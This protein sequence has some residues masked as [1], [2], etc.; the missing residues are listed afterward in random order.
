MLSLKP[1]ALVSFAFIV[2]FLLALLPGYGQSAQEITPLEAKQSIDRE[3]TTGEDQVY[4]LTLAAV[5]YARVEL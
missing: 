3:L 4:H 2:V 5:E 1:P